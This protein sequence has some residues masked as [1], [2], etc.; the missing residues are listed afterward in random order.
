MSLLDA[1]HCQITATAIFDHPSLLSLPRE[2]KAWL[3][4]RIRSAVL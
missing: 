2:A 4:T 1:V 3:P